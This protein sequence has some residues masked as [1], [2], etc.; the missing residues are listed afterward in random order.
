MSFEAKR[1]FDDWT[2][3]SGH[4]EGVTTADKNILNVPE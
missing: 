2:D 1:R 3:R 4:A